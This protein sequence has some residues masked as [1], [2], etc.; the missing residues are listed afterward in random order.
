MQRKIMTKPQ[1]QGILFDLDGTLIDSSPDIVGAFNQALI[2][3]SLEPI[4]YP[5]LQSAA[6]YGT[7]RLIEIAQQHYALSEEVQA[8]IHKKLWAIYL[9]R[10][11]QDT[12]LYPGTQE[13][14]E[15]LNK[16]NIPWGIVTNKY[17]QGTHSLLKKIPILQSQQSLVCG[18]TLARAKPFPDPLLLAAEEIGC[19]AEHCLFVGD[20][21]I[22]ASAAKAAGMPFILVGYSFNQDEMETL[23]QNH[24]Q[25]IQTPGELLQWINPS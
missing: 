8:V 4:P 16:N 7:K 19:K 9:E 3:L 11:H 6:A 14:L 17:T 13:M 2:H 24:K 22:D 15:T 5:E 21:D 25:V 12:Q 20:T 18:D 1:V 10:Q 23:L